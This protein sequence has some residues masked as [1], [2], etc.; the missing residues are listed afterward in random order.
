MAESMKISLVS[1][2]LSLKK[3]NNKGLAILIDP[4][5]VSEGQIDF[6]TSHAEA[7][8]A[9]FFLVGG[10]LVKDLS[11]HHLVP[12]LKQKTHLPVVIFPGSTHQIS[13]DADGILFLSLISGRNPDLLIGKHVEAAPL[14]KRCEIEIISTGYM[15]IDS[16]K[17]TTAHYISNTLPIPRDKADIAAYTAL[18]GQYLGMKW[19]YLDG[20][21]GAQHPIP[22]EMIRAVQDEVSIPLIVGGGIRTVEDAYRAWEAGADVVVIGS[23]LESSQN[24]TL[25]KEIAKYR[26]Q[27]NFP[28]S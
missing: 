16:G 4:D 5:K 21:S 23:A 8:Q 19:I 6:L 22:P 11:I 10:S 17:Y 2:L 3:C 13:K 24:N 20:G 18:A 9:T 28:L 1:H 7:C 25:M 14:L 15:L 12:E 27:S 26:I